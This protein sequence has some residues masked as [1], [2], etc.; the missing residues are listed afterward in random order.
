MLLKTLTR[1]FVIKCFKEFHREVLLAKAMALSGQSINIVGDSQ[2]AAATIDIRENDDLST[3][4]TSPNQMNAIT[5]TILS[6]LET[7]LKNQMTYA[8]SYGGDFAS[9]YYL[10]AQ[11]LMV[12]YADEV[13]LNLNWSG[14]R[15]WESNLLE[16][17]MYNSHIAGQEFFKRL[18]KYLLERDP[19]TRD[20]GTLYLWIL[21]LGF[22]GLYRNIDDKGVLKVYRRR[23]YEFVLLQ[24]PDLKNQ[25]AMLFEQC[26]EHTLGEGLITK[27]PN[28]RAYNMAF[29]SIIGLF[30]VGSFFVWLQEIEPLNH[31]M[32]EI[33]FAHKRGQP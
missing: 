5:G 21:G 25:E 20:I 27:L 18:D 13:F 23:L 26:Y 24:Q 17:R 9:K 14:R 32:S 16:S 7:V 15:E 31:A 33:I 30:I 1:S 4:D 29:W 10:E 28:P 8:V 19:A 3:P 2:Q 6:K 11:Y 22:K 12:A